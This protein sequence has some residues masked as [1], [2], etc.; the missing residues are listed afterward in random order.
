MKFI[1]TIRNVHFSLKIYEKS[2]YGFMQN[3]AQLW[4]GELH[5]NSLSEK[6]LKQ[7]NWKMLV[8]KISL[9]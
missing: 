5:S 8:R 6:Q 1:L 7:M 3:N 4:M 2:N 9:G